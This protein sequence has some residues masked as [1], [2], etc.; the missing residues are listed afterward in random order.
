V[1]Y[2][3]LPTILLGVSL[4]FSG[5]AAWAHHSPLAE[6]DPTTPVSVTGIIQRVVWE[7]PH[8]WFFVDVT[9]D[10]GTVTTWGFSTWPPGSLMRRGITKDVLAIGTVVNVEGARARDGSTNS[11]T[12]RLTLKDGSDVL[13]SP[14]VY[15]GEQ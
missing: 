3:R 9:G 5:Q 12:R 7:N 11:S 8:V 6:F 4:V 2:L 15:L 14:E 13:E 10:H 1:P